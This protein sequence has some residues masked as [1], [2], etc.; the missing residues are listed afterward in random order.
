[1]KLVTSKRKQ[2]GEYEIFA[3]YCK[4]MGKLKKILFRIPLE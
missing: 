4:A 2:F 3:C 1:M